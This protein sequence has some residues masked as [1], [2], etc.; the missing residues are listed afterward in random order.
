MVIDELDKIMMMM[1]NWPMQF[2]ALPIVQG[3]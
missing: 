3:L 1:G 2:L